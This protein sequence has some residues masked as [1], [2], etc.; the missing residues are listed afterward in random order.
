MGKSWV[1][2]LA[3]PLLSKASWQLNFGHGCSLE[4]PVGG[5]GCVRWKAPCREWCNYSWV[6]FIL[7]L[8]YWNQ[9]GKKYIYSNNKNEKKININW[10]D[11]IINQKIENI[12]RSCAMHGTNRSWNGLWGQWY[13]IPMCCSSCAG[14]AHTF[15]SVPYK[16][17]T[18]S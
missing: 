5:W 1:W 3:H 15:E 2:C 13:S 4:V 10:K 12:S 18:R 11:C 6:F 9:T 7:L 17:Y 8:I 16:N 14:M